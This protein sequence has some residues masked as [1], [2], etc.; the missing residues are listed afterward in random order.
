MQFICLAI[1]LQGVNLLVVA[2]FQCTNYIF[3]YNPW[4]FSY[5]VMQQPNI[6][7]GFHLSFTIDQHKLESSCKE[8]G[9]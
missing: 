5:F 6:L 1:L 9:K 4:P 3:I 8:E 2:E 7:N